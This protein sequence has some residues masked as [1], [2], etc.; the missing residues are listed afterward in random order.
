MTSSNSST[1]QT[2]RKPH[3]AAILQALLVTFLWSTSWVLVKYGLEDIPAFTFAGMRYSLAFLLLLPVFIRSGQARLLP[4]L[5]RQQWLRLIFLGL[6]YYTITQGTQFLGLKLL[7]AITFSLLLNLSAPLV[8][9]LSIPLLKEMPTGVQWAG[10]GIFL[11][12]VFVYFYP[13][14]I[15]A[16]MA[17]G[18]LVGLMSV[19]ATSAASIIGRG[20]NRLGQLPALT[21]TVV[22]MGIG[23]VLLLL[24][25]LLI[26]PPPSLGL[27]QWGIILWLALVNTAF[28]F[29]LWNHTLRILSAT[30]SSMINNTMLIQIAV[31]A[32]IFLGERP[33]VPQLIGMAFALAG[34]VMVNLKRSSAEGSSSSS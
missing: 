30:E 31:L 33:G 28:A 21:V 17:F 9:L 8:A 15:P 6:V 2:E 32:W 29:T 4:H 11:V 12:G 18:L 5:T 3:L 27:A 34:T 22:S 16:G 24:L 25:G 7:P 20:I 1:T 13:V 23:G 14:F 19:A 10:I 26:E